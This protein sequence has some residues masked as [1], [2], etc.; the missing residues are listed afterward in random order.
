M[1]RDVDA[2]QNAGT[3]RPVNAVT[4]QQGG[5]DRQCWVTIPK[6]EGEKLGIEKGDRLVPVS[7]DGLLVFV[8]VGDSRE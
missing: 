5:E 8:P 6:S 2:E 7:Q 3:Y 1:T 4:V